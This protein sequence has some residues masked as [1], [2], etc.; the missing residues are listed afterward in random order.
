MMK[1]VLR[2]IVI[3]GAVA[4]TA[5]QTPGRYAQKQDS[6]PTF[7]YEEPLMEDMMLIEGAPPPAITHDQPYCFYV[8]IDDFGLMRLIHGDDELREL[9]AFAEEGL[10]SMLCL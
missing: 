1:P 8:Y 10:G 2:L 7:T 4:L 6:E 9:K 5:Y 3:A